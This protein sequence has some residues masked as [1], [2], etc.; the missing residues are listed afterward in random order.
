MKKDI[1]AEIKRRILFFEYEPGVMLNEKAIAA[2]FAVSRTPVREAFLKLSW[3]KL[4]TIVPRAGIMVT[5][6][7]ISQLHE[8]YIARLAIEGMIGR[9][10]ATQIAE[11]ELAQLEEIKERCYKIL[12]TDDKK[13][14]VQINFDFRQI[15]AKAANNRSLQEISDLLY[16]QTQRLWLLIFD[17]IL[18]KDLVKS[19]I[20]EVDQTIQVFSRRNPEEAEELR[21][22]IILSNMEMVKQSI[23]IPEILSKR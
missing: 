3:E 13:A 21:K 18:F 10:A 7:E 20:D 5:K 11:G 12:E 17:R 14:L 15:L 16:Y 4:I 1:Y 23:G 19:K 9:L 22:Q 6:V 2:E 8:V